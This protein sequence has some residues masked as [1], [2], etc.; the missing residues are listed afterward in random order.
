MPGPPLMLGRFPLYAGKM[1]VWLAPVQVVVCGVTSKHDQYVEEVGDEVVPIKNC[2]ISA[3][4][5]LQ[6]V[7]GSMRSCSS[8]SEKMVIDV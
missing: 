5:L 4:T 8:R 3:V 6:F 1:P 7:C 2:L